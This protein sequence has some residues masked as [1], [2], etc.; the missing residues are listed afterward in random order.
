[1]IGITAKLNVK[2]EMTEQFESV[3]LDLMDAVKANEPG[4]LMYQ[5]CKDEEGDYYVLELYENEAALAAHG[6][7]EHFKASGA[8]FKGVM[9]GPPEIK[10]MPAV[11]R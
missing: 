7:S 4:C 11:T 9:G 1:M 8:G 5:L 6:Q 2:P 3:F 10:R